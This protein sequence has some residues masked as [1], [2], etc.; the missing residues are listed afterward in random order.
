MG[1]NTNGK[2]SEQAISDERAIH[3][4]MM[5][6][7]GMTFRQIGDE[8]G[9]CANLAQAAYRRGVRMTVPSEEMDEARAAALDR[10]DGLE[11]DAREVL[12]RIHYAVGMGGKGRHAR[13]D[14]RRGRPRR[15]DYRQD[16]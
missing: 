9:V 3:A 11:R 12:T 4:V 6:H 10:L 15:P 8:L 13:R 14:H 2:P 1:R 7:R 16:A 5:R